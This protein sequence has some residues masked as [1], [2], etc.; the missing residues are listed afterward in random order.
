[1]NSI[2]EVFT[3][4][5]PRFSIQSQIF[6]TARCNWNPSWEIAVRWC[7]ITLIIWCFNSEFLV[8]IFLLSILLFKFTCTSKV[9]PCLNHFLTHI[10]IFLE[11]GI[12]WLLSIQLM[13]HLI[14]SIVL[15]KERIPKEEQL[16]SMTNTIVLAIKSTY[17]QG[18]KFTWNK[19]YFIYSFLQIEQLLYLYRRTDI[20]KL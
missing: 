14:Q 15:I 9:C 5:H 19:R 1:M 4:L 11:N 6:M 20:G 16:I 7:R 17:I 2:K 3:N 10:T 8:N 12:I 18:T 13:W